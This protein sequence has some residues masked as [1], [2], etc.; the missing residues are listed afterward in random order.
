M[1]Q[2]EPQNFYYTPSKEVGLEANVEEL[3]MCSYL[4]IIMQ[5]KVKIGNIWK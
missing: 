2:R 5:G 4:V 3:R 1:Q